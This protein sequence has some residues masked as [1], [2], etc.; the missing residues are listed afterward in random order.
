MTSRMAAEGSAAQHTKLDTVCGAVVTCVAATSSVPPLPGCATPS[1]GNKPSSSPVC[2]GLQTFQSR[3][4]MS[5]AAPV[6]SVAALRSHMNMLLNSVTL[7]SASQSAVSSG[8]TSK[9]VPVPLS[10]TPPSSC[11]RP[12][13]LVPRPQ[14]S[15]AT[16]TCPGSTSIVRP[17]RPIQPLPPVRT[18]S[19]PVKVIPGS[20]D[21]EEIYEEVPMHEPDLSRQP[22]R[23]ALKGSKSTGSQSFQQQLERALSSSQKV[24]GCH[25]FPTDS[26]S[27]AGVNSGLSR[28]KSGDCGKLAVK[29]LPAVPPKP[30]LL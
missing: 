12:K 19:C 11:I 24:A 28:S 13:V 8:S 25:P 9:P 22:S 5:D 1:S 14:T 6:V 18:S 4:T 10:A 2:R 3:S 16:S 15:A 26:A 23:S 21:P 20:K 17:L 27:E 30:R 29:S 7:Q